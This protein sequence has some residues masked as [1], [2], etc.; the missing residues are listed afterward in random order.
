LQHCPPPGEPGSLPEGGIFASQQ[1]GVLHEDI[2]AFGKRRQVE[3]EQ[4]RHPRIPSF[5]AEVVGRGADRLLR[6]ARIAAHQAAEQRGG[7]I[8]I[9]RRAG[10]IDGIVEQDCQREVAVAGIARMH[11]VPQPEQ[12]DMRRAVIGTMRFAIA[13]PHLGRDGGRQVGARQ[14]GGEAG[15]AL[16]GVGGQHQGC[17]DLSE[18]QGHR[19]S[20]CGAG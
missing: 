14:Q 20:R 7:A 15:E 9:V 6:P 10:I 2:G 12:A 17:P 4:P 13:A 19:V 3:V 18:F 5:I 8:L 1:P 16:F 11:Q